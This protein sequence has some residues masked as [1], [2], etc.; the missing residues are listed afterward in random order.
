MNERIRKLTNNTKKAIET[1]KRKLIQTYRKRA[2]KN[3]AKTRIEFTK[4][5]NNFTSRKKVLNQE[6]VTSQNLRKVMDSMGGSHIKMSFKSSENAKRTGQD[7]YR[8]ESKE[9]LQNALKSGTKREI[10]KS[11]GRGAL[12]AG[13]AGLAGYA[14]YKT[15]KAIKNRKKKVK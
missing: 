2:L 4:V 15:Y 9:K 8:K 5:R 3:D 13:A 14:G 10:I 6:K 12:V 7:I 11:V 1:G